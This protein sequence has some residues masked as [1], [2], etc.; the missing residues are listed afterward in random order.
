MAFR[1][2][3]A[4][5]PI[6]I[7][8]RTKITL[9][10]E[11]VESV[12]P[13]HIDQ[14][15]PSVGMVVD[16]TFNG[17]PHRFKESQEVGCFSPYVYSPDQSLILREVEA[18]RM[19][20]ESQISK[21]D[22]LRGELPKLD[23]IIDQLSPERKEKKQQEERMQKMERTIDNLTAMISQFVTSNNKQNGGK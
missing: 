11:I 13:P 17:T 9:T 14:S 20:N 19:S 4:G 10:S 7:F 21:V 12:T 16:V 23:A 1:D 6:Y 18:K 15:N 2:I 8:D 3:K 22:Q 5:D